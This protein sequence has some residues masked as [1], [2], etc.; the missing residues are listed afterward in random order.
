MEIRLAS[1][2]EIPE[3]IRLLQ[4]VGQVHHDI[5]PDL[6]RDGAQK[7]DPQSLTE[8]LQDPHRPVFAAMEGDAMLGYC[9]CILRVTEGDPVRMDEKT[10]YIDD[11]CVDETLRGHHVGKALYEY[12]EAYAKSIGCDT[13]TLNVWCGNEAAMA[14]YRNR[15]MK[16]RNITMEAKL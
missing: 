5:R 8:L 1:C 6:F 14:F 10:L 2:R 3:M 12:A 7:Y 16:P 13:I 4:Q 9:F 11:L 15:G